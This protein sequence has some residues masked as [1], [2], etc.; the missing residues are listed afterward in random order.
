MSPGIVVHEYEFR[1]N[2]VISNHYMVYQYMPDVPRSGK[3]T[4]DDGKIRTAINTEATLHHHRTLS[5]SVT[6]LDNI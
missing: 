3:I 5:E 6:F 2:T 4:R 1:A